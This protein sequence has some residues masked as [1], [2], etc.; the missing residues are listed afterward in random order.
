MVNPINVC[1]FISINDRLLESWQVAHPAIGCP[2]E[3][4]SQ[5]VRGKEV[6]N[7]RKIVRIMDSANVASNGLV[8]LHSTGYACAVATSTQA[9]VSIHLRTTS[10]TLRA[11]TMTEE[12]SPTGAVGVATSPAEFSEL[13]NEERI[14]TKLDDEM[15]DKLSEEDKA[16]LIASDLM[17]KLYAMNAPEFTKLV[18]SSLSFS[19]LAP[20]ECNYQVRHC[21]RLSTHARVNVGRVCGSSSVVNRKLRQIGR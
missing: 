4:S 5:V 11:L 1:K 15:G 21:D 3:Q 13:T 20:M 10:L 17:L 7:A 8:W 18:L 14:L 19:E 9:Q 16:E 12:A 6:T 2:I